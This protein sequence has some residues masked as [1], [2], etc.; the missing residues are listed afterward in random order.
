MKPKNPFNRELSD[1]EKNVLLHEL[2]LDCETVQAGVQDLIGIIHGPQM[3]WVKNQVPELDTLYHALMN[4][5]G[6]SDDVSS[7]PW[8]FPQGTKARI[9]TITGMA[10]NSEVVAVLLNP[11]S[12]GGD[13]IEKV[14]HEGSAAQLTETL[15]NLLTATA[16]IPSMDLAQV[17]YAIS[18]G[19]S[20]LFIEGVDMAYLI[21]TAGPK[22]R[23]VG[24]TSVENILRGPLDAFNENIDTSVALLRRRVH[25]SAFRVKIYQVGTGTQTRVGVCSI[26]SRVKPAV[27]AQIELAVKEIHVDAITDSG[28]LAQLMNPGWLHAF[29]LAIST[30]RPDRA[31]MALFDGRVVLVV[32]T[33]PFVIILPSV[34]VDFFQ[35]MEDR[36]VPWIPAAGV[37]ILRLVADHI[38]ALAPAL[39]VVVASFNPGILTPPFELVMAS[40]RALVPYSPLVEAILVLVLTDILIEATIR[41]PKVVGNA[42]PIVGG[43]IIGDVLTKTHLASEVMLVVGALAAITQF[44]AAE[45][46]ISTFE[47][48]NKYWFLIWAGFL[49]FYGLM[50]AT[51][52]ELAYLANLESAG[53][54]YFSPIAPFQWREALDAT[55]ILPPRWR[56]RK[57]VE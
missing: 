41:S 18:S 6:L 11:L 23:P 38:A 16:V 55:F 46:S 24:K 34:Y 54:P 50:I 37:R 47:R 42:V 52:L 4:S 56:P 27:L 15:Q 40:A 53:T 5:V 43:I 35:A 45:P 10:S 36:Y 30:E 31:T 21:A 44:T 12:R 25:D 7:R 17:A 51:A 19:Q 39:Y 9:V 2:E 33:S 28:Q 3:A 32:D 14:L 20:G 13:V 26:G 49:G 48:L 57:V 1:K 8:F 29:P 22:D